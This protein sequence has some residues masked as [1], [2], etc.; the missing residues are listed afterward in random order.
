MLANDVDAAWRTKQ[1]RHS[2]IALRETLGKLDKI[3]GLHGSRTHLVSSN[4][5]A[6]PAGGTS[7]FPGKN[8]A[9]VAADA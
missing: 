8:I 9:F 3:D 4:R 6:T 7:R 5:A 1:A 2:A